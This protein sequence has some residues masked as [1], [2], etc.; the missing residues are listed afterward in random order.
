M[1]DI[2]SGRDINVHGDLTINDNSSEY[3]LIIHCNNNELFEEEKHRRKILRNERT[4]KFKRFIPI[5][6]TCAV[7]LAFAALWYWLQGKMDLFSL[8]SGASGLIFGISSLST[9]DK[10][11]S[12]EQRQLDV[13]DE[14]H[15]LLRD[16][17]VR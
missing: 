2:R 16:R 17:G 11:N 5:W 4:A 14:I 13:L 8:L 6:A 1:K 12:F 9:Y 7:A 10:P 15:D 3:K